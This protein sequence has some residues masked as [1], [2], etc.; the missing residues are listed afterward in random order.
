MPRL[1]I[2]SDN[3]ASPGNRKSVGRRRG[4]RSPIEIARPCRSRL[5]ARKS[6]RVW[7]I[8][9]RFALGANRQ[10]G[11]RGRSA[12]TASGAL[13]HTQRCRVRLCVFEGRRD[14]SRTSFRRPRPCSDH[15]EERGRLSGPSPAANRP[16]E[17]DLRGFMPCFGG[18]PA[19]PQ[20][21]RRRAERS[22]GSQISMYRRGGANAR[23]GGWSPHGRKPNPTFAEQRPNWRRHSGAGDQQNGALQPQCTHPEAVQISNAT[24]QE[25]RV[26][27]PCEPRF[28]SLQDFQGLPRG[29][30]G[31]LPGRRP[32]PA[33]WFDRDDVSGRPSSWRQTHHP[34]G[35]VESI[36][37]RFAIAGLLRASIRWPVGRQ[38]RP[39]RGREEPDRRSQDDSGTSAAVGDCSAARIKIRAGFL[40]ES[41]L[42]KGHASEMKAVPV[43]GVCRE[44]CI[45][46]LER[47]FQPS[48][49]VMGQ[50]PPE[51]LR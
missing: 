7:S 24:L 13:A 33:R 46:G 27:G 48:G 49:I 40:V 10:S 44:N 30:R 50:A 5:R 43:V 23:G 22:P 21:A 36:A 2:G 34:A 8:R 42:M 17:L 51:V 20:A 3:L 29:D 1:R 26:C 37:T 19:F 25:S 47:R 31:R 9:R 18:I 28:V 15:N 32:S 14:S 16:Q 39:P 12:G 35:S 45:V 38:P 41:C 11:S 4:Q 6:R